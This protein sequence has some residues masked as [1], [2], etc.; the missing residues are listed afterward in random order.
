MDYKIDPR[1]IFL[2]RSSVL[3]KVLTEEDV[4]QSNWYGWFNDEDV[5]ENLQKHYYPNTLTD[6]LDF[7]NNH[8]LG[9]KTLLQLG[10]VNKSNMKLVGVTSLY[11]IDNINRKCGFS[12]VIGEIESRNMK[13]FSE[14][15]KMMFNH[16]FDTLNLERVYGGSISKDITDI[17]C[18]I[19]NSSPEGVLRGD[20]YKN[21]KYRDV[22]LYGILKKEFKLK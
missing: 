11:S 17:I 19:T 3:L 7:Y 4:K 8:I 16:A 21:G 18:R 12:I 9:N 1:D 13:I 5:C 2:K 20:V 6:Q 14:T 22:Y 10:I 15:T